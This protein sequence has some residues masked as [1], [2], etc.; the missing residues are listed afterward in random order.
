MEEKTIM[1]LDEW[2]LID[3][4][5]PQTKSPR[6]VI[7]GRYRSNIQHWGHSMSVWSN[8]LMKGNTSSGQ[9]LALSVSVASIAGLLGFIVV[10]FLVIIVL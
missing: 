8:V 4:L 3:Y 10:F 6:G 2:G 1:T 5:A 7:E 9:T